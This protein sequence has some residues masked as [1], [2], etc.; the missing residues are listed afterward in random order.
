MGCFFLTAVAQPRLVKLWIHW[1]DLPGLFFYCYSENSIIAN[2]RG[3]SFNLGLL[4]KINNCLML[5][6]LNPAGYQKFMRAWL[7]CSM[8]SSKCA[9]LFPGKLNHHNLQSSQRDLIL[10]KLLFKIFQ[11]KK[12]AEKFAD[13]SFQLNFCDQSIFHGFF[14][15]MKIHENLEKQ[16]MIIYSLHISCLFGQKR[17]ITQG[18]SAP[19]G[20]FA[21][22][23]FWPRKFS[24]RRLLSKKG[25]LCQ[26]DFFVQ[27][28]VYPSGTIVQRH[29]CNKGHPMAKYVVWSRVLTKQKSDTWWL[30]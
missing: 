17:T 23:E 5:E 19:E 12:I 26:G 6:K 28:D 25:P 2:R 30:F 20:F 22:G 18:T 15:P 27:E 4:E 11:N 16:N 9:A 7:I 29:L 21:Q 8:I 13:L 1:Q 10:Q 3:N 24:P 14:L